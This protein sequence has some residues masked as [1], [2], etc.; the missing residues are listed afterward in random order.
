MLIS[1]TARSQRRRDVSNRKRGVIHVDFRNE[2]A[3]KLQRRLKKGGVIHA[4][5]AAKPPH[6]I[7]DPVRDVIV[8]LLAAPQEVYAFLPRDEAAAG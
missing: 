6:H 7:N 1:G 5:T 8:A 4:D 2:A 3:A